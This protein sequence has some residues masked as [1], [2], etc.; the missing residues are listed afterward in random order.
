[1]NQ[2]GLSA[3]SPSSRWD[4]PWFILC[5]VSTDE[6]GCLTR[7][8]FYLVLVSVAGHC[9]TCSLNLVRAESPPRPYSLSECLPLP[10]CAVL[11]S[12]PQIAS[13]L[14]G[15]LYWQVQADTRVCCAS[16]PVSKQ[17]PILGCSGILVTLGWWEHLRYCDSWE[18]GRAGHV[19][20]VP[21]TACCSCRSSVISFRP[22]SVGTGRWL[23]RDT[24]KRGFSLSFRGL[25]CVQLN[26]LIAALKIDLVI[27]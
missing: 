17:D 3:R 14:R 6:C 16:S 26:F 15:H 25:L 24:W 4:L 22:G 19:C 8:S 13:S 12:A 21:G 11:L 18:A 5:T 2:S 27:R 7:D 20:W 1:M 10:L 23:C 9:R